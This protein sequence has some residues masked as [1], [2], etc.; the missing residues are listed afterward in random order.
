MNPI[1]RRGLLAVAASLLLI[2]AWT[3]VSGGIAQLSQSTTLGQWAQT[4]TQFLYG[5]FALL[6]LVTVRWGRPWHRAMRAS[7]TTVVTLSAGLASVTW[8]G[9]SW[10]IGVASAAGT[11]LV[12]LAINW[13]ISAGTH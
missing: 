2:L 8:G 4:A 7:W 12:A 13:M 5:L 9:T 3:G 6:T 11:L 10:W 1:V